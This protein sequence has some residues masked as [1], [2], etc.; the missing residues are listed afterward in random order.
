MSEKQ[1][2]VMMIGGG[3]QEIKAVEIAQSA[4][5]KVIVTD[6]NKDAPCFPSA[7]YIA[8]IDGRDIEG[9]IAYTLLN[10]EKLNIA[11]VFT[12]TELVTSV[13]AVAQ[14]CS[15]PGVSL[16]SAVAC[17]NKAICKNIWIRDQIFAP[18]GRVV[19]TIK[20]A[21]L[22]FNELNKKA[23]VKPLVGFGGIGACKIVSEEDIDKLFLEKNNEELLMEEL[24]E[25]TMH[26]VNAVFD[27]N[28]KFIPL[29]CFDRFFDKDFPVE[30][31]AVYPSQLNN[32]LIKEAYTLTKNAAL[33][34]G[35]KWGPVKSDLVL[36]QSGFQILEMAPRLHGPKGSLF[37]SSMVDKQDH[38][39]YILDILT[40]VT[41]TM[42]PRD[43]CNKVAV[44]E[45][46][47]HPGRS[48]SRLNGIESIQGLEILLLN[49]FSSKN[50]Y[51]DNSD[52]IG[53]I[54]GKGIY[55]DSV[56]DELKRARAA[57]RFG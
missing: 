25:G 49:E 33:S 46:I 24:V 40:G 56:K 5:Y 37:L 2:T 1:K 41:A 3:I 26:D 43:V 17:Q 55:I 42:Q 18:I 16:M 31:G 57:I 29:G 35:I 12:L 54:F 14:A 27:S 19:R 34:L 32:K 30:T 47:E 9:L 11:G 28:G 38:L 50:G 36:T 10:K 4:G 13:A 53:Y 6:R 20:E 52:V 39:T 23:F 8:K 22:L 21:K 45:A 44:Y 7:D 51:R 48:F 15:L